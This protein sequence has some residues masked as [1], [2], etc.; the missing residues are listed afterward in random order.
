MASA[1]A[2]R[3]ADSALEEHQRRNIGRQLFAS[4]LEAL[5]PSLARDLLIALPKRSQQSFIQ[6]L[7]VNRSGAEFALR[8]AEEG[9][10]P[11][12]LL[13]N[14]KIQEQI[15]NH[16]KPLT[17]RLESLVQD[18]PATNFNRNETIQQLS[19]NLGGKTG[20]R[21]KGRRLFSQACQICHQLAGQGALIGPQL[22][23]IGNRGLERLLEDILD[24][25]RNLD[26]AFHT[27]TLTLSN[28]DVLTG[29]HRRDDGALAIFANAAGQEF[30]IPKQSIIRRQPNPQSLMPDNFIEILNED[31]L[32]DLAAFL[33]SPENRSHS[34]DKLSETP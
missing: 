19:R 11:A 32:A 30:S 1:L 34:S 13:Q 5:L 9:T 25:N 16:G 22:D 33:L 29:L 4:N 14:A 10:I 26:K 17:G 21:E 8:L 7:G 12:T 18:L 3:I 20:N 31:Q 6:D 24:P 27:H 28:G 15:R 2:K 23:G